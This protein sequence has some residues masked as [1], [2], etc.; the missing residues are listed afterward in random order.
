MINKLLKGYLYTQII[1]KTR[2]KI[3][4]AFE[5]LVIDNHGRIPS[6][7]EIAKEA[8]V[9][10][11]AMYYYFKDKD[12]LIDA[13][14]FN[15]IEKM[16]QNC[17]KI[18]SNPELDSLN[19]LSALFIFYLK[20]IKKK[21]TFLYSKEN[22]LLHQKILKSYITHLTPIL[23][24]IIAEGCERDIF[25]C[26]YPSLIAEFLLSELI[27]SL[28]QTVMHFTEEELKQKMTGLSYVMSKLL[29]T[30]PNSFNFLFEEIR[31]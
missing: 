14:I 31:N 29:E 20:N 15:S 27:I 16:K 8:K 3:I 21:G 22:N 19:K 5:K 11:G 4:T 24:E 17:T 2:E 13:V 7:I 12:D 6:N 26:I 1:M 10:K 18:L 28:D 9:A 25:N 23:S 30:D